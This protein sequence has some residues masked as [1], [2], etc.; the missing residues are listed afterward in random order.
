MVNHAP[1]LEGDDLDRPR[2]AQSTAHRSHA[3]QRRS[4][5]RLLPPSTLDP[6]VTTRF[7]AGI[8]WS[9]NLNDVAVVDRTG[10]VLTRLRV[11]ESPDGVRQVLDALSGLSRSH[12]HSRRHVPI[13]IESPT[14]LLVEGLRAARQPVHVIHPSMAARYRA[15]LSPA[16]A[17][18]DKSDAAMLANILRI[19]GPLHPALPGD[20]DLA[21]SITVLARAHVR[22]R[23]NMDFHT[24]RL[25]SLLRQVHPAALSAWADLPHGFRR[26]EA[27][28]VLAAGPTPRRAARL[29]AVDLCRILADAGRARLRMDRAVHLQAAFAEPV[30]RRPCPVEEAMGTVVLA[31]LDML[32]QACARVI[33]SARTLMPPSPRTPTP[34]S[35]P[36]SPAA[37]RSSAPGC[38]ARSATTPRGSPP[39]AACAPTPVPRR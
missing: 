2:C 35:T 21:R 32:N 19:D 12:R 8:D 38:S 23:R 14:S 7:W 16:K 10:T 6:I 15:R 26:A 22:A 34:R 25:R 31:E 39:R 3:A 13:A 4:K 20:S 11:R 27:R 17:K 5:H 9:E 36:R 24:A 37:G 1:A 30:V 28:A 33:T 18:S 29:D